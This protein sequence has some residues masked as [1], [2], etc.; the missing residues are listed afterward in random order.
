MNTLKVALSAAVASLALAGPSLAQN[1]QGFGVP[2]YA[3][4]NTYAPAQDRQVSLQN[5]ARTASITARLPGNAPVDYRSGT[6]ARPSE[7]GAGLPARPRI[8]EIATR[9]MTVARYG[10]DDISCDG[11][12]RPVVCA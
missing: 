6:N 7:A 10:S 11:M 3:T 5:K 8:H 1:F 12:P 4:Q 2:N 9:T